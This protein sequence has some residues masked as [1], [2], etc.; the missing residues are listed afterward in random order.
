MRPQN[1]IIFGTE[2]GLLVRGRTTE[3]PWLKQLL[4]CSPHASSFPSAGTLLGTHCPGS[5]PEPRS[6][7]LRAGPAIQSNN[8]WRGFRHTWSLG[9][10]GLRHCWTH[11]G[12]TEVSQR[13]RQEATCPVLGARV[14]AVPTLGCPGPG[15][16]LQSWPSCLYGR[17]EGHTLPSRRDG[18]RRNVMEL[19]GR[20]SCICSMKLFCFF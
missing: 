11:T 13:Q 2:D 6:R 20:S 1:S 15:C 3:F 10:K 16:L 12:M 9:T 8:P 14:H 4:K 18:A 7:A 19:N 17:K 5:S